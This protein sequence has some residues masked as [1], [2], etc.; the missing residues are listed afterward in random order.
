MS[1]SEEK[2]IKAATDLFFEAVVVFNKRDYKKALSLFS[3]INKTFSES[4]FFTVHEIVGKARSYASMAENQA[5]T[6][7]DLL[8]CREDYVASALLH[9][10]SN[11]LTTAMDV[12]DQTMKRHGQHAKVHYLQALV[13]ARLGQDEKALEVL[14]TSINADQS[15]KTTAYNE[16]DFERL[17]DNPTF[18]SLTA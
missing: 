13:Y 3:E 9:L 11:R 6:S 7:E 18:R 2:E 10:N 4:E 16:P 8:E 1:L 15:L 17:V 5:D 14:Q 12:L